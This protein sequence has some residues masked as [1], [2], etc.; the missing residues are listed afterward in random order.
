MTSN[1]ESEADKHQPVIMLATLPALSDSYIPVDI[2]TETLFGGLSNFRKQL[3][4]CVADAQSLC[5]TS[6]P[7]TFLLTLHARITRQAV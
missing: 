2:I 1:T 3:A 6:T 5:N 7:K 4:D